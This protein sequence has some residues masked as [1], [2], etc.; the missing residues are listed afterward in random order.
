LSCQS[1]WRGAAV[2]T[3]AF[4]ATAHAGPPYQTDDPEPVALHKYEVNVA[5]RATLTRSGRSGAF[6]GVEINYDGAPD[7]QLHL[8]V[9][10]A[11]DRGTQPGTRY[12]IGD[13]ELGV[14]Y[15]WVQETA[16]TR[17]VAI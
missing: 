4:A 12:G 13:A 8:G 6:P 16:T 15:R 10:L 7:V 5:A 2:V 11:F 14:K 17:M 3:C 9:P 1:T